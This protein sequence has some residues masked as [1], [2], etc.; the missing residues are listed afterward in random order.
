MFQG[1]DGRPN[2]AMIFQTLDGNFKSAMVTL[3]LLFK[4][5]NNP[6]HQMLYIPYYV[7]PTVSTLPFFR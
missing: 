4:L 2:P 5:H 3:L 7:S 1:T 6:E